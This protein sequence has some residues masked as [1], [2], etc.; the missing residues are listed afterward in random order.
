MLFSVGKSGSG[1]VLGWLCYKGTGCLE[2]VP[3][4]MKCQ[5]IPEQN[6]QASVRKVG[7]GHAL[8]LLCSIQH[9]VS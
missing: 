8:G 3:D 5:C 7:V 1:Y 2:P 6:V 9:W 4:T